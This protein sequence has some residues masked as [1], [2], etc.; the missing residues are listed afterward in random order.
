LRFFIVFLFFFAGLGA[1]M[2]KNVTLGCPSVMLLQ[3]A[4]AVNSDNYVKLNEYAIAN[5]CVIISRGDVV[6]AIG[7]DPLNSIDIFQ[8]ILYKRT[9]EELYIL[10]SAVQIEQEGKKSSL[11][12]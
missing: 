4:P 12:F 2:I 7:Y 6:Q 8:K 10:R 5:N 11:R 3:K 9:G 1:D